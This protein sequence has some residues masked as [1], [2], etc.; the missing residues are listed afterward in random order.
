MRQNKIVIKR[1]EL[2]QQVWSKPMTTLSKEYGISDVGLGKICKKLNIPKPE[3]GHWAK[4]A[5]GKSV[6]QKELPPL[7]KGESDT[8]ELSPEDN[9]KIDLPDDIFELIEKEKRPENKILVPEKYA[10]YHK[11]ISEVPKEPINITKKIRFMQ[12]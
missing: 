6:K 2:F 1:E 5:A 7:Q 8:Y 4:I 11:M 10:R 9:S 3:S 12:R